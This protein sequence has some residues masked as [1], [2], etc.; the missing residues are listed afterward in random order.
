MAMILQWYRDGG[1]SIS[2]FIMW[3]W[4]PLFIWMGV[5]WLLGERFLPGNT[6]ILRP[7]DK[8]RLIEHKS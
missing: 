3:N 1:I 6:I 2:K 8:L 5:T 4:L 7:G